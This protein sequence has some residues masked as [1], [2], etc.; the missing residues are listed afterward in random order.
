MCVTIISSAVRHARDLNY[1]CVDSDYISSVFY[2]TDIK[3]NV[4][5]FS[6]VTGDMENV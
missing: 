1:V 6:Q 5:N 2:S 3:V 4:I